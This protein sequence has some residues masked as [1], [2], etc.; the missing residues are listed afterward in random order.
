MS[1][2]AIN[3][4]VEIMCGPISLKSTNLATVHAEVLALGHPLAS[5]LTAKWNLD[6]LPLHLTK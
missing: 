4:K 6:S 1:V 5:R 2:H 3:G